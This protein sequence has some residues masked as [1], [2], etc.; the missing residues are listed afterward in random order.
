MNQPTAARAARALVL[1]AILACFAGLLGPFDAL[2]PGLAEANATLGAMRV[3]ASSVPA[4]RGATVAYT[5]S[6]D[7]VY[8][9]LQRQSGWVLLQLG[10]HT[11]WVDGGSL[12]AS[13]DPVRDVTASTLN[14]RSGPDTRYRILGTLPNGTSVAVRG[15]QGD[16]RNVSYEGQDAWVHGAYLTGGSGGGTPSGT[17][18]AGFIPLPASGPGY[19][20]YSAAYRRWGLPRMIYG[21][22]RVARLWDQQPRP[23]LGVG[24]V[25]LENGG[26]FPPHVSHQRGVDMDVRPVRNDGVEAPVTIYDST[27]SRART[28]TLIDLFR[29]ETSI[30][31]ILFND[32]ATT[33]TQTW[34]GHDNH[35]HVRIN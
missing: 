23:R 4:Y 12:A 19:Y 31:L 22:Q 21:F 11:A 33:G 9:A 25:S 7:Q 6:K 32:R 20:A 28:Q 16:W 26:P 3:T 5:L 30:N 8:P 14:V 15:S 35:L 2:G 1:A 10:A 34:P 13:Q 17:S 29:S 24:D 18:A 27:Y